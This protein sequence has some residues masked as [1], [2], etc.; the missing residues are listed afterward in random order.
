MPRDQESLIDIVNAIRRILRYTDG[1]SQSELEINDEKLSA[2]LYQI[3]II[4]EATKR[5]SVIFR[6]QHPEIPWREM[7]GMRDVIV[8]K[9]D[10]LDLDVVWDIV[11]NKLTELLKAIAPLL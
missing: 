10:Q 3:T 4:G 5:L 2:I 11:E 6:Q 8:H 1:I 7:A 9:Y